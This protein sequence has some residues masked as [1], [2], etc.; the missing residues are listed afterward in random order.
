[1]KAFK[2]MV[3]M[4]STESLNAATK[5]LKTSGIRATLRNTLKIVSENCIEC[6]LCEKECA[7]LQKY[8][9]PKQIADKYDPESKYRQNMA[10]ECSLCQL[11]ASVCPQSIN[12]SELFLEMR[13]EAVSRG[14]GNFQ[15]Y[16]PILG[17]E[18]RGHSKRFTFYSLPLGCDTILFP[19]CTLSGTRP[20]TV[21][22]LYEYLLKSIPKIGIVLDCCIKPSH[23][24][25]RVDHFSALFNE[26]RDYLHKHGVKNIL[27]A[28]PN[29]FKVFKKYGE[30]F[31]TKTVY[32]VLDKIDLPDTPQMNGS[33]G[34]HDPCPLRFEGAVHMAVRRIIRKKGLFVEDMPHS[35]TKS[36]CCGDGGMVGFVSPE[37]SKQWAVLR[38]KEAEGKKIITYCAGCSDSLNHVTSTNHILDLVF[39]PEATMTGKVKVSKTPATYWNRIKL[40]RRL[41]KMESGGV[42]MERN[43]DLA[44]ERKKS[45]M[46]KFIFFL[47]G[48]VRVEKK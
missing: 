29:C 5:T 40:K 47:S 17:Y 48:L 44:S 45:G 25:G 31:L 6:G 2:K 43:F 42:T 34:V 15:G 28:C 8:G 12:P 21:M 19:G 37:L 22:K 30:G 46:K 1:M 36:L 38:G 24:L 33:V 39:E 7:F 11:C 3:R 9:I 32:E 13:R 20:D 18:R 35:K 4:K 16:S 14:G 41:K 23:D 27:V 26:M 10:F